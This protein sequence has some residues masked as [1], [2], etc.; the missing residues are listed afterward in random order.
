MSVLYGVGFLG[1]LYFRY[2]SPSGYN[3]QVHYY[4]VSLEIILVWESVCVNIT[5]F[6]DQGS[7][8]DMGLLYFFIMIPPIVI[9]GI[10][11]FK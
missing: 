3:L 4:K 6:L 11:L 10:Y 5:D 8:D 9:G 7:P 2:S 1:I